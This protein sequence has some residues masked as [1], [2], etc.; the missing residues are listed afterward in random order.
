LIAQ[1]VSG[2]RN[3]AISLY[4]SFSSIA[5]SPTPW[6]CLADTP[7]SAGVLLFLLTNVAFD[8]IARASIVSQLR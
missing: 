8:R 3:K 7:M 2:A 4:S 6:Q 1:A 5:T